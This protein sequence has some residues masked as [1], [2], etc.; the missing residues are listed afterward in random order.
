[1]HSIE[2]R[3]LVRTI[4]SSI[5]MYSAQRIDTAA[6]ASGSVGDLWSLKGDA[7]PAVL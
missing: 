5:A 4:S 3:K 6:A 7:S 2:K 1:M